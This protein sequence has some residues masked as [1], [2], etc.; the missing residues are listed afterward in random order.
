[1]KKKENKQ[2]GMGR[3]RQP[4][5]HNGG[6]WMES[7]ASFVPIGLGFS[8]RINPHP[9]QHGARWRVYV[10]LNDISVC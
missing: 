1:M 8:C 7:L 2:M 9:L 6:G 5:P 3:I 10:A 4:R